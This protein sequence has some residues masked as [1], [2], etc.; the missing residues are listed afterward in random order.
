MYGG[1]RSRAREQLAQKLHH[2][3][4]GEPRTLLLELPRR[5]GQS[6]W[7]LAGN[8][9]EDLGACLRCYLA[10]PGGSWPCSH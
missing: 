3:H 4:R 2:V 7:S 9:E 6:L 8:T 10:E 5:L 1:R